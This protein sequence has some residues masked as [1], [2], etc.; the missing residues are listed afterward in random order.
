MPG[1]RFDDVVSALQG[2]MLEGVALAIERVDEEGVVLRIDEG[3]PG[4]DAAD[5]E[6]ATTDNADDDGAADRIPTA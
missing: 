3:G 1:A 6:A 2:Q 4:P 5:D